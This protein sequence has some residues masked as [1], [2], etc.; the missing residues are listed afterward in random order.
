MRVYSRV[1][2]VAGLVA[3]LKDMTA[4]EYV[5]SDALDFDHLSNRGE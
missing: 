2:V 4:E 1:R 3:T 5:E